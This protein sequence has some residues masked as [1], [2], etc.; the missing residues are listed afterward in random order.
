MTDNQLKHDYISDLLSQTDLDQ[1]E[2]WKQ[3]KKFVRQ[4]E[5][6]ESWIFIDDTI[7]A[8]PHSTENQ[9]INY[10]FDYTV[11]KSVKGINSLNFLLSSNMKAETVN[12]PVAYH[13]IKKT[14]AFVD[15]KGKTKFKSKQ[16]KNE[17]L[18]K[19]LKTCNLNTFF[20]IYGF[21][22]LRI[23]ILYTRNSKK[24]SFVQ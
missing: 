7:C 23:W 16:T 15:P 18:E 6:D 2:F 8:K 24:H 19:F 17:I 13:V 14:E 1:K 9:V 11:G 10:H 3:I 20:L 12:C 22:R 21:R 4:I 5:T